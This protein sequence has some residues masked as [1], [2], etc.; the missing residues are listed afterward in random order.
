MKR[1]RSVGDEAIKHAER[2]A[3]ERRPSPWQSLNLS[4]LNLADGFWSYFS[5]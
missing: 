5:D 4:N 1:E 2:V 3:E